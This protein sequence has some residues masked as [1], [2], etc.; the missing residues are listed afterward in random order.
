M[1]LAMMNLWFRNHRATKRYFW[2][3]SL[4]KGVKRE[5]TKKRWIVFY[6]PPVRHDFRGSSFKPK[7]ILEAK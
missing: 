3:E 4:W 7:Q 2:K 5:D 6:S 1:C